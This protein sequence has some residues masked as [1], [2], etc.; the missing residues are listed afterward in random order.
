MLS[1][2]AVPAATGQ[3]AVFLEALR[4]GGPLAN[5]GESSDLYDGLIGDWDAE[6][7]DHLPG[8]VDRPQS[9]EMHFGWVLEGRAV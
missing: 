9:A 5:G 2:F 3:D 4:A 7:V 1:V 8:G 6:V